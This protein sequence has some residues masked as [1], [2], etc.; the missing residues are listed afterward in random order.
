MATQRC[1]LTNMRGPTPTGQPNFALKFAYH[2]SLAS[3]H[4][5]NLRALFRR[6]FQQIV[7]VDCEVGQKLNRDAYQV[8]Y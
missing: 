8:L 6:R 4:E 7:R 5:A 3:K 1:S 2:R